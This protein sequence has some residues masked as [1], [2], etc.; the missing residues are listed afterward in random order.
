MRY[1]RKEKIFITILL[2]YSIFYLVVSYGH[3][4]IKW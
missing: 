4:I 1:T 2:S 3:M